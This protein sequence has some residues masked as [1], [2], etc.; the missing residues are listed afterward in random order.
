MYGIR[1]NCEDDDDLF[2]SPPKAS[3]AAK[4]SGDETKPRRRPRLK[5][6]AAKAADHENTQAAAD[7]LV[8]HADRKPRKRVK[9]EASQGGDRCTS[10]SLS[11]MVVLMHV[12]RI[13][14]VTSSSRSGSPN[15]ALRAVKALSFHM[16]KARA[17]SGGVP[18]SWASFGERGIFA[19]GKRR[20]R[21]IMRMMRIKWRLQWAEWWLLLS[22]GHGQ[23][24]PTLLWMAQMRRLSSLARE[25]GCPRQTGCLQ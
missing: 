4:P 25:V 7:G 3:P 2:S 5:R 19:G 16:G 12:Y 20:M 24:W 18:T 9:A 8:E 6:A 10:G 1:A 23:T 17:F 14:S 22:S 11:L 21:R 13:S 15:V